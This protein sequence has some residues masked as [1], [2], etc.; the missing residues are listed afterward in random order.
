[1]AGKKPVCKWLD[2]TSGLAIS[3]CIEDDF[4]QSNS[5]DV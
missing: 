1:L 5:E 2:S 4:L 3:S